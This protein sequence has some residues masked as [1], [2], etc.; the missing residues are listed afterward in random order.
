MGA[1]VGFL[2]CVGPQGNMSVGIY[3]AGSDA[4]GKYLNLD[5]MGY[6]VATSPTEIIVSHD[7][8]LRD[9]T[10][11]PATGALEVIVNGQKTGIM[12]DL[13][14]HQASNSGR[15]KFAYRVFKGSKLSVRV[16][17]ACAA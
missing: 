6:P 17:A 11:G 9:L 15:T 2:H 7:V 14:A 12:M 8:E 5:T 3:F 16:I 13:A 4:A 1:T 10:S